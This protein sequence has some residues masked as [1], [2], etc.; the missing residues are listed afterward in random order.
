MNI[1]D[2]YIK[3]KGQ[4]V[5]FIT[6]MP[7]CGKTLVAKRLSRDFKI[8]LFNQSDYYKKDF[9]LTISLPDG[10]KVVN[11]YTD[12][13]IDWTRLNQDILD[14]KNRSG[15]V[16]LYGFA[17]PRDKFSFE[18]DFHVHLGINKQ[19]C[20]KR[21]HDFLQ[22]NKE[23]YPEDYKLINS[24]IEKLK[25][26]QLIYPY[27]LESIKKSKINKF[28]DINELNEEQIY[29]VVF[30]TLIKF[31]Q[32]YID[33]FNKNQYS[34]WRNRNPDDPLQGNPNAQKIVV[35]DIVPDEATEDLVTPDNPL[36]I[37]PNNQL[38]TTSQDLAISQ[39]SPEDTEDSK[40]TEN[41]EDTQDTEN[42]ED[43]E[44]TLDTQTLQT[45]D[46]IE[47]EEVIGASISEE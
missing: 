39:E 28:I 5:I 32:S 12:E 20:L 2:A 29:D 23:Q 31:I 22:K 26:N 3:F 27:Y 36:L 38:L 46:S 7:G 40:D 44:D 10:S 42:S 25:L 47:E 8:N 45:P 34:D 41:T 17:L 13:A 4:L 35:S 16:V 6:G 43:I 18:V 33:W 14:V 21:R 1:V 9:N 24:K 19:N 37:S 30:D 11:L 15:G